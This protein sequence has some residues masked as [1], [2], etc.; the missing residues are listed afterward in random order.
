[1]VKI[2]KICYSFQNFI[3]V[4]HPKPLVR[5][6]RQVECL[7]SERQIVKYI[8]LRSTKI[9]IIRGKKLRWLKNDTFQFPEENIIAW[10]MAADLKMG[11][12]QTGVFLLHVVTIE[13]WWFE[14]HSHCLTHSSYLMSQALLLT[15]K[16]HYFHEQHFYQ[17]LM[18]KSC[19]C[20]RTDK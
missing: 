3:F 17:G 13:T 10:P 4:L 9:E 5:A 12:C 15:K 19:I 2:V 16:Q 14:L 11:N 18:S 8:I 7:S 20:S 1:M 6:I